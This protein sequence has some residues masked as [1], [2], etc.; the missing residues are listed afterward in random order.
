MKKQ[1]KKL[2]LAKETVR[3]L[4]PSSLDRI[5]GGTCSTN[6]SLSG[7][8]PLKTDTCYNCSPTITNIPTHQPQICIEI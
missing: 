1:A 8:G 7:C 6:E 3:N 5:V 2:K 4:E